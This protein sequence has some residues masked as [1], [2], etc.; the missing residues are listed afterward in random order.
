MDNEEKDVK[1]FDKETSLLLD[2]A[3]R[4]DGNIQLSIESA[5]AIHPILEKTVVEHHEALLKAAY[6]IF[7]N[8][9]F[10]YS[11]KLDDDDKKDLSSWITDYDSFKKF[12]AAYT[13][14]TDQLHE[15]KK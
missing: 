4:C 15:A 10:V 7:K 2:L 6:A 1:I 9:L 13:A 8:F 3:D 11:S 12:M 5:E 14:I